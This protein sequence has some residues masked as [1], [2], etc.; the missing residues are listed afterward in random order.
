MARAKRWNGYPRKTISSPSLSAHHNDRR[1][2]T[3]MI[4]LYS[5]GG[6]DY[7]IEAAGFD[8]VVSTDFDLDSCET[9]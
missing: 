3:R 8:V 4:S 1:C 7:G 6:L 2:S 5:G 9:L